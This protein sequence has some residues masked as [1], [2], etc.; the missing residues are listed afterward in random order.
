ML[1]LQRLN[2]SREGSRRLDS[3]FQ[4]QSTAKRIDEMTK[5]VQLSKAKFDEC[6]DGLRMRMLNELHSNSER[7]LRESKA[8]RQ[9]QHAT[10]LE[11]KE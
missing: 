1:V 5:A 9:T 4:V 3:I 11:V 8:I 10:L 6:S 7:N 2:L